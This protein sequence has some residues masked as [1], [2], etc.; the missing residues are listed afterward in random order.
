MKMK[1]DKIFK[2]LFVLIF[3]PEI[4]LAA[5]CEY[6]GFGG[7]KTLLEGV[8]TSDLAVGFPQLIENIVDFIL[9]C[10]VFY[11]LIGVIIWGGVYIFIST[12]DP[13]KVEKGKRIIL[14]GI[15]GLI[16]IFAAK[17]IAQFFGRYIH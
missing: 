17:E 1:K 15:I 6:R 11:A 10:L 12:G 9:T 14:A 4:V 7:N 2:I 5:I 16:I 13:G 3:I 8:A